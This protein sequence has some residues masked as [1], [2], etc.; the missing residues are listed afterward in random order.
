MLSGIALRAIS[1]P[2]AAGSHLFG[3][4][5]VV[6]AA[7]ELASL[8]LFMGGIIKGRVMAD[9]IQ[10]PE[11]FSRSALQWFAVALLLNLAAT[12]YLALLGG[13]VVPDWLDRTVIVVE[14]FG[15]ITSMIFGVNARNLPLFMRIKPPSAEALRPA[16]RLLPAAVVICAAG[17]ALTVISGPI[18]AGSPR[19]SASGW[20]STETRL[21]P[22]S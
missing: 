22:S 6:S 16:L 18:P 17:Q 9:S 3:A 4:L 13:S 11:R 20:V 15:F 5:T 1:Q 2:L 8:G 12:V 14:L 10:G 7:L 21:W 19:L